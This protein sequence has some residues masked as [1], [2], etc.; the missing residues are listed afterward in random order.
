[1]SSLSGVP[2]VFAPIVFVLMLVP[3]IALAQAPP[4]PRADLFGG[5]A[6]FN[7]DRSTF[8]GAQVSG[9]YRMGRRFGVVGDIAF[10]EERTTY[11]GGIRVYGTASKFDLFGQVL[12]GSAPL[13]DIA[14]Q[15]GFGV[16][17]HVGSRAAIRAAFD[18]KL[19]GDGGFYVGT[20]FSTGVVI[21]LGRQ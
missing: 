17:I 12:M 5:V 21:K 14:F 3:G 9:A 18:V 1:M 16:D 10:Y 13:D 11:M 7:E 6:F 19:S 2:R 20:R 15:P 8:T 4:V